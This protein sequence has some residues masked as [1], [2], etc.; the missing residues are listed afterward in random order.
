VNGIYYNIKTKE[1]EDPLHGIEDLKNGIL[2]SPHKYPP[3][4]NNFARIFRIIKASAK[5]SM[6]IS[7]ELDGYFHSHIRTIKV[8]Y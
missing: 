2:K 8:K 3:L 5:L 1:I 4:L 7:N 6:R